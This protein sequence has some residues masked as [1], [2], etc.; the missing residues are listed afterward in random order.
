VVSR[1]LSDGKL[2]IWRGVSVVL[3]TIVLLWRPVRLDRRHLQHDQGLAG[4]KIGWRYIQAWDNLGP[5]CGAGSGGTLA[6]EFPAFRPVGIPN[7]TGFSLVE[8]W[9]EPARFQMPKGLLFTPRERLT[10]AAA[11]RR[12]GS[13]LIAHLRNRYGAS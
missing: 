5:S 12:F 7:S 8:E 6:A 13:V 11:A 2:Q 4:A 10:I 1:A 3:A 9:K